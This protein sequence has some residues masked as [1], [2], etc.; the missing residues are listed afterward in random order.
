M[1][2][3]SIEERIK[4]NKILILTKKV[5]FRTKMIAEV[6]VLESGKLVIGLDSR[7]GGHS[8]I[9]FRDINVPW[10]NMINH[11]DIAM[12]LLEPEPHCNTEVPVLTE[13]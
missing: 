8:S 2:V 7:Y 4:E 1:K 6:K 12:R 3:I 5:V 13:V 9:T 11:I 10:D